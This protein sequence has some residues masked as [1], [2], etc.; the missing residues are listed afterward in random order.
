MRRYSILQALPLSFFSR[1]LYRDVVRSWRGLGLAY[2]VLLVAL[3]TLVFVIRT[4]MALDAWVRGEAQ[5]LADQ[6][7]RL[8]IRQRVVEVDRPM[9]FT[10]HD[11]KTGGAVAVVDTTGQ[12]VS[13]D[14]LEARLLLTRDHV[15]YRKSTTETRVFQLSNVKDFTFDSTRAKRWLGLFS[16]WAAP[17]MAPFVFVGLLVVRFIQQLVFGVVGLLVGRLTRVRLDFPAS[18][19]LA[20]VALTPALIIEPVLE[21]VRGKPPLWGL[22]WIGIVLSYIV[23]AVRANEPGPADAATSE[24]A[25]P[26]ASA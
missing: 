20:A 26:Q 13:L 8:V 15:F 18:M 2:L 16:A 19:R 3:L 21:I 1:D 23:W 10:I 5:G 24:P 22:L 25:A 7:P 17:V 14:G 4:G 12:V 11:P 6:V 9:P